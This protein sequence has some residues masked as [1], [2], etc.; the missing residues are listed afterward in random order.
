[1]KLQTRNGYDFFVVSS[2]LQKSL[3]RGDIV[4]AA[5][6]VNELIPRYSNY[7]WNRLLTV[8]A[9]DCADLV[10]GEVLAC[11]LAWCKL[12]E[13][14]R[15]GETKKGTRIF[16]QKAVVLLAKAKHARDS[17]ELGQLVSDRLP[18]DVFEAAMAEAAQSMDEELDEVPE[19]VYDIH[20]AQGKRAGMTKK[21]FLR[22]E[23][24]VMASTIYRNFDEM[25]ASWGYVEPEFDW[26]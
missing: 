6:S 19:W 9:E 1:M 18:D 2:L 5:R 12:N 4:L 11:Y 14:E 22:A 8:S 17:D 26:E 16:F 13:N 3:R 10:T 24:N 23:H 25:L 15:R 21:D 20:T 7:V